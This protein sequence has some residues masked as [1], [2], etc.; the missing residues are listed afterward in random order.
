MP[1]IPPIYTDEYADLPS[2]RGTGYPHIVETEGLNEK[3]DE[4]LDLHAADG[5]ATMLFKLNPDALSAFLDPQ[6]TTFIYREEGIQYPAHE[7]VIFREGRVVT[8]GF[9]QHSAWD[10]RA[11]YTIQD[12]GEWRPKACFSTFGVAQADVANSTRESLVNMVGNAFAQALLDGAR[13]NDPPDA[14]R[15]FSTDP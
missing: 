9:V 8:A 1:T 5:V 6:N 13:W 12:D 2:G 3:I 14:V 15:S 11:V 4:M 10:L 7:V